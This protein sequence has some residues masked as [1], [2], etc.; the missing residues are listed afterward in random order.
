MVVEVKSSRHMLHLPVITS[1]FNLA[2]ACLS[3][4]GSGSVY[5]HVRACPSVCLSVCVSVS[6]AMGLFVCL[7]FMTNVWLLQPGATRLPCTASG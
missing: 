5:R 7:T 6:A 1:P 3:L 4:A 2:R